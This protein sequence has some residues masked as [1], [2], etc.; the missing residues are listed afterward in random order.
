MQPALI[1]IYLFTPPSSQ[2]H[3]IESGGIFSLSLYLCQIAELDSVVVD[4]WS[5]ADF[6][7]RHGFCATTHMVA[8]VVVLPA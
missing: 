2:F 3:K 7:I 4:L 5:R 1:C 8:D 6:I